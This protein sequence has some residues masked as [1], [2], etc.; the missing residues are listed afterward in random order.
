ME[1]SQLEITVFPVKAAFL[2]WMVFVSLCEQTGSVLALKR[3]N[4]NIVLMQL[5]SAPSYL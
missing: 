3:G 2:G 4:G 5:S 1:R